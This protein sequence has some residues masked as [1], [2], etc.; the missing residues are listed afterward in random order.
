MLSISTILTYLQLLLLLTTTCAA[1]PPIGPRRAPADDLPP[2]PRDRVFRPDEAL[3]GRAEAARRPGYVRM[4]VSRH[5]FNGTGKWSWG[6]HWGGGPGPGGPKGSSG[7]RPGGSSSSAGA[8]PTV[9]AV[10]I[11]EAVPGTEVGKG[12]EL[13]AEDRRWGWSYLTDIGGIAYIIELEIGTPPQ[14]IKVFIDTGSYELWVNPRCNTSASLE[15]CKNHGNYYP[16]RSNSSMYVGGDFAVTYGTGAVKGSYWSDVMS[17]S[18]FRI[19]SVQFAVANDSNYTFSGILGLGYAYPYSINYPS[20]LNLM[21]SQNMISAPIFS[22]GLGGDGDNFSEIIFGGVNR[23]KFAGYLEPIPI[24]PPI[25]QQD[26]AWIQYWINVTSVGVTKPYASN[27]EV[28]TSETFTMPCLIDT[29]STLSYIRP[30]LV[31]V[32]GE[33]FNATVD[34]AGNYIVD[35][36]W[37]D[38]PGTVDFGFN[39]GRMLINVRYK[40]FIFQQYPGH[41]MLGVQPADAGSTNYVLGDTFIRGAYLVFDQQSDVIWMNQYYNCGDQVVSVGQTARDTQ[42]IKGAC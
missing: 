41:C 39:R 35:C 9:P 28:Y 36:S 40:D 1:L 7:G 14:L 34:N 6:W 27:G 15:I 42:Y 37:R 25:S 19:P 13:S 32:I 22:V 11:R 21:V 18:M 23:W 38:K 24:W 12:M 3:S 20:I 5:L 16:N 4:P 29:G 33:K 30:D 8:A 17:V 2:N 31:A 26:P 10:G